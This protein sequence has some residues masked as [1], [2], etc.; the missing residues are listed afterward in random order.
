M[1]E[2][3]TTREREEKKKEN[4]GNRVGKGLMVIQGLPGMMMMM[5]MM[6]VVVGDNGRCCGCWVTT[7]GRVNDGGLSG[8]GGVRQ[9]CGW[10]K[11]QKRSK[12]KRKE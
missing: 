9:G 6:M 5:V 8:K 11:G 1:V 10:G 2:C 12:E 3:A 4:E 7:R